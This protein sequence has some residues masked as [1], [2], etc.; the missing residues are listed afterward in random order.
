MTMT[1]MMT[2]MMMM[3]M[4]CKT[5]VVVKMRYKTPCMQNTDKYC[6]HHYSR[7]SDKSN[8]GQLQPKS[9]I[10]TPSNDQQ[11]S[12]T[13]APQAAAIKRIAFQTA[14]NVSLIPNRSGDRK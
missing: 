11:M 8:D 9:L 7:S 1:M 3:M 12:R 2:M 13:L 14:S 6:L 4:M 5:D 10:T